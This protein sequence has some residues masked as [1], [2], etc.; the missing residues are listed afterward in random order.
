MVLTALVGAAN[1]KRANPRSDTFT[2]NR[3]FH[4]I[5][6]W[7]ADA[8][9]VAYRFCAGLGMTQRE[10]SDTSTDNRTYA[11]R[12]CVA[13]NLKMVFSAPYGSGGWTT[14]GKVAKRAKREGGEK[15]AVPY[16]EVAGDAT[17]MHEFVRRHG[18]AVRAVCIEVEDAQAAFDAFV[19]GVDDKAVVEKSREGAV[20]TPLDGTRAVVLPPTRV[21]DERGEAT[22]AEVKLYGD[23]V[24]RFLSSP[25]GCG[26]WTCVPG[27]R[28]T[29]LPVSPRKPVVVRADHIVGNVFDL[30]A[31]ANYLMKGTGFHEFAEFT[32]E[33]VG[34]V[35]SGLNSLVL[36][37][38]EENVLLPINEPTYGTKRKSQILTYLEQN[39][40]CGVQHIALSTPDIVS[41]VTAM[42][43]SGSFEFL[44]PPDAKHYYGVDMPS[45]LKKYANS[46]P[47][48]QL[49]EKLIADCER[50]DILIDRDD[51]GIL[52]QI[53]TRPVS[54]RS[55]LFLEV[56]QR[57]GCMHFDASVKAEVQTPGCGGFGKGN[58]KALFASVEKHES[59]MRVA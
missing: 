52:L 51:R 13:G 58:F 49:S 45:R 2:S 8:T 6:F 55:T 31:Q 7:C 48:L 27:Y 22:V 19:K 20:V 53:F 43:E 14:A 47:S 40:G 26:A 17:N 11:S 36:A 4:H 16:H 12:A 23:V 24:L 30:L 15:E 39:E 25:G 59:A 21:S 28:V 56:I 3:G 9:A 33:D 34:T 57:I 41:A 5:E 10:I 46:D 32:A 37:N 54:D 29:P 18:T 44:E 50:L 1:F 38:N 35:D 42:R